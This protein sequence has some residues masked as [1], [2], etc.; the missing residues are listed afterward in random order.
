MVCA[1]RRQPGAGAQRSRGAHDLAPAGRGRGSTRTIADA[2]ASPAGPGSPVRRPPTHRAS[3]VHLYLY[4]AG[5]GLLAGAALGIIIYSDLARL[6]LGLALLALWAAV[7]RASRWSGGPGWSPAWRGMTAARRWPSPMAFTT[8]PGATWSGSIR[9][10]ARSSCTP[11]ADRTMC[12]PGSRRN[13]GRWPEN[14]APTIWRAALTR[15]SAARS[16]HGRCR[17]ARTASARLPHPADGPWALWTVDTAIL[18]AALQLLPF[19]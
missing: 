4:A 9:S 15:T 7:E 1:G 12:T 17:L 8:W 6:D 14:G 10:P 19:G 18:F 2:S 3:H 16:G 11:R 13:D 5:A